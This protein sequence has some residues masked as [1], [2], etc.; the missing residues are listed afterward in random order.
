MGQF[1]QRIDQARSARERLARGFQQW[2]S[3]VR[4][5]NIPSVSIDSSPVLSPQANPRDIPRNA[6]AVTE[7][8]PSGHSPRVV[9]SSPPRQNPVFY[10]ELMA[11]IRQRGAR[12]R[13]ISQELEVG[14]VELSSEDR[15]R[16][17][18]ELDN[19]RQANDRDAIIL[20]E[21]DQSLHLAQQ[22]TTEQLQERLSAMSMASSNNTAIDMRRSELFGSDEDLAFNLAAEE[23]LRADAAR[24]EE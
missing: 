21:A 14:A 5:R 11:S 24:R 12:V 20:R 2:A 3:S 15:E 1:D 18:S 13:Q 8:D 4:R 7:R 6:L 19:H 22:R 10:D 16:F 17:T 9:I 23:V